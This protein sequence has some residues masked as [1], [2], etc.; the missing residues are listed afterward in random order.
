MAKVLKVSNAKLSL[1]MNGKQKADIRFL[2]ALHK[3]F[4]IDGNQLL[5]AV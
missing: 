5:E 3:E 4:K 1:I 2:K